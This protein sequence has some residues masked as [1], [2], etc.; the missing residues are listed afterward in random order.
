V[1]QPASHSYSIVPALLFML[2]GPILWAMHLLLT[3][4]PQSALCA[5]GEGGLAQLIPALVL[6]A[7]AVFAVLLV[8][9]FAWPKAVASLLRLDPLSHAQWPFMDS[10][11]RNLVALSFAGVVFNGMAAL[12]IDPCAQL[13]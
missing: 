5:A 4:G 7:T 6:G 11:S 9:G 3:Y 12:L 8:T 2:W 1:K 13:R 10:V